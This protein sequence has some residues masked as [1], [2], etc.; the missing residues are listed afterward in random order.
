MVSDTWLLMKLYWL[1]DRREVTSQSALRILGFILAA[2][3]ILFISVFSG[4]AGYGASFLTRS[5]LPVSLPLGLVPG[6]LLTFVLIGVLV[7]GMNQAVKS[8]FLSGDLDRLMVAP[9]HTRSVMVAKL[10]SRAP[11]NLLLLLLFAAPAFVAY[12]VGIG[13]GPVYFLLGG[14]LLLLAPLFGLSVGAVIAMLLVR[15]LP[16]NRLNELLTAAYAF[17][18]IAI[19][20]LFQLP[21]LFLDG[22][23]TQEI[24]VDI[25]S[26]TLGAAFETIERLPIPTLWAG[27]GLVA[28]DAGRFEMTGVLGILAYLVV[29][30]GLFV[31]IIMTAD[32]LYLSGW[33]K[34][35]TAGGKRQGLDESKGR[36]LNGSLTAAI[37][38]KDWLLRLR[39]PRQMVS[40]LG[41]GF[42][43]I[44]VGGL[45]IF[46]G[47]GGS[48]NQSLLAFSQMDSSGATGIVAVFLA[49][50][51]PGV[52][53]GA[54]AL[55][56][57]S[58]FLMNTATYAL[59]LEGRAFPLLK[60]APIRPREVWSAKLWSIYVPFVLLFVAVLV[61]ARFAVSYD[62]RWLPYALVAGLIIGYGLLAISVSTGFRYALLEWTDPRRMLSSGGGLVS[63]LLSVVYGVPVAIIVLFGFALSAAW[64]GWSIPLALVALLLLAGLTWVTHMLMVRWA[65]SAWDKLPV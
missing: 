28:L 63:F 35:Q 16:V 7:F 62:L 42:V 20:L 5:D 40:L 53:M 34:T 29:T 36:F 24:A 3:G 22:G 8:L 10:L 37:G 41:G 30:L 31:G 25:T 60:A 2:I 14:G 19:A 52:L 54:W 21:R 61:G 1:L 17:V 46:R 15:V 9:V 6:L 26:G 44:V 27:R 47:S 18:G 39:D 33:L 13:A 55:F 38:M 57:G 64:T 48:D 50:F 65:D 58:T 12:G 51:S 32:R 43:A 56:V 4:L 45:A 23:D 11:S 49:M 59:A